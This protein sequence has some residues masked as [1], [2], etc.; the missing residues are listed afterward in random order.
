MNIEVQ[1]I[2]GP[3]SSLLHPPRVRGAGAMICF[4]GVV[5]PTENGRPLAALDYEVYE[6]MAVRQLRRLAEEAAERFGLSGVFVQ[7][8]HGRVGAG[9][10]SFRLWIAA[11]HRKEALAAMDDF[12]DRLKRDV[13]IWKSPVFA[14]GDDWPAAPPPDSAASG[15]QPS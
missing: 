7:H 1:I 11:V 3:L 5:R 6:P 10:C 2:R 13:P 8:S 15:E 9:E 14:D 12:I 4:E